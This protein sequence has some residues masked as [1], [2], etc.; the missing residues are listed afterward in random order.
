MEPPVVRYATTDDGYSLAYC[1]RGDGEPLV[2]LPLGLNHVQLAWEHDGRISSWL[3][4]LAASFRLIQYDHRGQGMSRRGLKRGHVMADYECDLEAVLDKLRVDR[5]VL[6]GYFY[7]GHTAIRFAARHPERVKAL[8]LISCSVAISAWPLDS[9]LT[10]AEQNWDAMLYNWVPP[11]ATPQ[12]RAEYLAFFK[13]TRTQEDWLISARAFSTS[14][15]GDVLDRVRTPA[16]VMHP[17][18]FLWLA[19]HESADLASRMP[20]ALFRL[21]DGVL[22]LGDASQGVQ[23]IRSF[24]SELPANFE[25]VSPGRGPSLSPREVEVLRLVTQG[26]TNREIARELVLSERTVINHL[27]HIFSKTGAE[28]RA[29]ATAYAIRHGLV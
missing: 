4:Q 16:L 14:D 29:G 25:E 5:A 28:N 13:Q 9:L 15:V 12:E 1:E 22:P 11:T 8:V 10:L 20:N 19:P 27:S 3:E 6:V 2:F 7:S 24:L 17:R 26:K 23:A 18:E 21:I